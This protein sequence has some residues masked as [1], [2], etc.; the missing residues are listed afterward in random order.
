M[1]LRATHGDENLH[2]REFTPTLTLPLRGGDRLEP[3]F[4][5]ND[6]CEYHHDLRPIALATVVKNYLKTSSRFP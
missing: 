5:N 2:R 6:G 3:H 4:Q 1:A